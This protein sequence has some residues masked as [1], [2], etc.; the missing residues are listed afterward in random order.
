[1]C[2]RARSKLCAASATGVNAIH[3]ISSHTALKVAN[4]GAVSGSASRASKAP[5]GAV[6]RYR[7]VDSTSRTNVDASASNRE[8][9][10][11]RSA[12]YRNR[13]SR[14][15]LHRAI[16]N[17]L[18]TPTMVPSSVPATPTIA[19][20]MA[21]GYDSDDRVRGPLFQHNLA[22][23]RRPSGNPVEPGDSGG[24]LW[25]K[26]SSTAGIRGIVSL[27]AFD[28]FEGWNSFATQY[29]SIADYYVGSAIIP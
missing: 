13:S 8:Y 14:R 4:V 24:P 19:A 1:M 16:Q 26:Y 7:T 17:A 9:K 3:L 28:A 6:W 2:E 5:S 15:A 21:R 18:T 12:A 20:S 23:F 22:E 27:R 10:A 29:N 25:Y 11:R